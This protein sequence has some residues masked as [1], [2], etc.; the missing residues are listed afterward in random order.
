MARLGLLDIMGVQTDGMRGNR[1]CLKHLLY[2]QP[3]KLL[4]MSY[5][6][7]LYF[8]SK[9]NSRINRKCIQIK[10]K[11]RRSYCHTKTYDW[12]INTDLRLK[13]R[14]MLQTHQIKFS[15]NSHKFLVKSKGGIPG[16]YF[17]TQ[18]LITDKST[19][20]IQNSG[21]LLALHFSD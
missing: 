11:P 5:L 16:S 15:W 21:V 2:Q 12:A 4:I 3:R 17:K 8:N 20:E 10:K 14:D 7:W 9:I 19:Q 18:T 1:G 6:S 13:G